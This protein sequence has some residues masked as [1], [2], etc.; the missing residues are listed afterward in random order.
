MNI[1]HHPSPWA[2]AR[3][4]GLRGGFLLWACLHIAGLGTAFAKDLAPVPETRSQ[5]RQAPPL[6]ESAEREPART[7]RQP[8]ALRFPETGPTLPPEPSARPSPT[9]SAA[10]TSDCP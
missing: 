7:E 6:V 4:H 5:I 9:Q 1:A 2:T 10:A 8:D 3:H